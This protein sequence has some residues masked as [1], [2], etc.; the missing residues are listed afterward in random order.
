MHTLELQTFQLNL[1]YGQAL[2]LGMEKGLYYF[3]NF[4]SWLKRSTIYI[5]KIVSKPRFWYLCFTVLV[6]WPPL[7]S[8]VMTGSRY[9]IILRH[10]V[11]QAKRTFYDKNH[12]TK[13]R[14]KS[15]RTIFVERTK[16]LPI[17]LQLFANLCISLPNN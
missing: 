10:L 11:C 12:I 9:N 1:D 6:I 4:A 16:L 15:K 5:F 3:L 17:Q 2:L 8:R 7:K 13:L 14:E